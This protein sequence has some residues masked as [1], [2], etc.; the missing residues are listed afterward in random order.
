[1]VSAPREG[2]GVLGDAFL[3][4]PTRRRAVCASAIV[5]FADQRPRQLLGP[6]PAGSKTDHQQG[7]QNLGENRARQLQNPWR[8]WPS[9]R[10]TH[11]VELSEEG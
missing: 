11:S 4:S 2:S 10:G 7:R 5:G 6:S 9:H 1:M 3:Y 8:R